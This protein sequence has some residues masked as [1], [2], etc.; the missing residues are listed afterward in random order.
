MS[1]PVVRHDDTTCV[2]P[3][4]EDS[5]RR[6]RD[7]FCRLCYA[8]VSPSY[9]TL[10]W[11]VSGA[12][13]CALP[14]LVNATRHRMICASEFSN[15]SARG[16]QLLLVAVVVLV[17]AQLLSVRAPRAFGRGLSVACCALV[18]VVAA[19]VAVHTALAL[20]ALCALLGF[21][22]TSAE[23]HTSTSSTLVGSYVVVALLGLITSQLTTHL[24]GIFIAVE[25]VSLATLFS[26]VETANSPQ[27]QALLAYY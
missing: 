17:S 19:L 12:A 10:L 8:V 25:L 5:Q 3:H 9:F 11:S 1:V 26:I 23:T 16:A 18:A 21:V 27:R 6:G 4:L 15:A 24:G 20:V 7:F 22:V 2:L 13:Y 14:A